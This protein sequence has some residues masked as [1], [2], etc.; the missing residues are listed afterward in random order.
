MIRSN[1]AAFNQP[2]TGADM[3]AEDQA[4]VH[5]LKHAHFMAWLQEARDGRD[6]QEMLSRE[7]IA[8]DKRYFARR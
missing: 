2:R 7:R 6:A 4:I 1:P 5:D 3:T 8:S